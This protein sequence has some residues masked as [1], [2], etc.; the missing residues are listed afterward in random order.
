MTPQII[1]PYAV[2]NQRYALDWPLTFDETLAELTGMLIHNGKVARTENCIQVRN[3]SKFFNFETRLGILLQKLNGTL[4]VRSRTWPGM[5]Q[6]QA[7]RINNTQFTHT[8][9]DMLECSRLEQLIGLEKVPR[10]VKES[11]LNIQKCFLDGYLATCP[12]NFTV[13]E[14]KK[15]VVFVP[16]V[17]SFVPDLVAMLQL[18]NVQCIP[19]KFYF[20]TDLGVDLETWNI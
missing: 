9:L 18:L 19:F 15:Y 13:H 3:T 8:F 2:K 14:D 16:Y 7:P 1:Y 12:N 11:P 10:I 5:F 20:L 6:Q 17:E 4:D